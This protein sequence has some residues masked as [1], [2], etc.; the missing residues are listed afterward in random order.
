MEAPPPNPNRILNRNPLEG[1]DRREVQY[2]KDS[3]LH[4]FSMS[5]GGSAGMGGDPHVP[6]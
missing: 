2:E 1:A 3:K 5:V 6:E 4:L